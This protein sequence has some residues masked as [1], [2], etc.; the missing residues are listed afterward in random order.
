MY[1]RN[2]SS[3]REIF[4]LC[5]ELQISIILMS[6]VVVTVS[7]SPS[8]TVSHKQKHGDAMALHPGGTLVHF[9][10][11]EKLYKFTVKYNLEME[12]LNMIN[13]VNVKCCE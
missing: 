6:R 12:N 1:K 9:F 11:F 5:E 3:T 4:Y 7:Q 10:E 13:K 2:T 8:V